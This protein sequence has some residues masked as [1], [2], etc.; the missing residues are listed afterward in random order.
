MDKVI[1][2]IDSRG[3]ARVTLNNP[4]KHNAFDDQMIIELTNAFNALAA[5]AN[6]RIM[7]LKSEGKSFSAGADLDWMK[8]MASYS[9]QQNLNDARA[10]AAML[11]ALHQMPIPTIA[12]VQG[13]TFGGAVGLISCCD[14][15]LASSNASFALSEVKIGLVPST[16]SPYVIAAIGERHAKRYF[17][18]AERFDANTALQID[19][20][21]E[22][23]EK[24]LLDD[25]VEQ[26]VTAILSNGPEAVA[27]AKQL[28][29][30]VSGKP[31]DSKLIEHT[32]EVIA[33][34]RVSAQGQE[35]LSAFLDK[36]KPNWLKD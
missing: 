23:V 26:L 4:D 12:R 16:I 15:A 8:R 35:G 32:C 27:V 29:F 21:H 13:A 11:K 33:G 19:L 9:Y 34:I 25:K 5:N 20:V 28:I 24:S 30:A 7:L 36:R 14:I 6:V 22:A 3:V 10:L 17:M 31:I 2:Q 1:T 18:T